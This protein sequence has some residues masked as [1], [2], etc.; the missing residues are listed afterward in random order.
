MSQGKFMPVDME[1]YSMSTDNRIMGTALAAMTK[2]A[3]CSIFLKWI[4]ERK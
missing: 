2:C 3:L 1:Y 4:N